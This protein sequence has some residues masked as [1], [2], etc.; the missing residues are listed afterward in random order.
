MI[1]REGGITDLDAFGVDTRVGFGQS[2]PVHTC[3]SIPKGDG[4]EG[5]T[6]IPDFVDPEFGCRRWLQHFLFA[7]PEKTVQAFPGDIRLQPVIKP[8]V[9]RINRSRKALP[10]TISC[11]APTAA[12]RRMLEAVQIV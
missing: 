3:S 11:T 1:L 10:V 8:R 7:W 6:T 12:R 2:R 9:A 4:K 5:F